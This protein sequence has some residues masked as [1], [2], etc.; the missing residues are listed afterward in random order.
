MGWKVTCR[1]ITRRNPFLSASAGISRGFA[2]EFYSLATT[3]TPWELLPSKV[4]TLMLLDIPS[5]LARSPRG[6]NE[7]LLDAN[8]GPVLDRA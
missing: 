2:A 7:W 1:D 3:L 4:A 6:R 5:L 8:D